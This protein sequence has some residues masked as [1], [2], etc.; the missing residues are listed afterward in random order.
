M[1]ALGI[2]PEMVKNYAFQGQYGASILFRKIFNGKF[3][4]DKKTGRWYIYK[5]GIFDDDI[6]E[7]VEDA[8]PILYDIIRYSIAVIGN[9]NQELAKSYGKDMEKAIKALTNK[10]AIEAVVNMASNGINSLG[11]DGE[12]WDSI[13]YAIPCQNGLYLIKERRLRELKYE[14]HIRIAT[15]VNYDAEAKCPNFENFINGIFEHNNE[16]IRYFKAFIGY[17]L[18]KDPKEQVIC[19]LFGGGSN[20]KSLLMKILHNTLGDLISTIENELIID[21]GRNH[22]SGSARPEILNLQGRALCYASEVKEGSSFSSGALKKYSGQDNLT[23]RALHSNKYVEFEPTHVL[24]L[25]TNHKPHF[26]ADDYAMIRRLKLIPFLAKFVDNPKNKHEYKKDTSFIEKI[27]GEEPGILNW[28]IEGAVDWI[29][30]GLD[31]LEPDIVKEALASYIKEEDNIQLFLDE[32]CELDESKKITITVL[33][34][35]YDFWCKENGYGKPMTRKKFIEKLANKGY[36]KKRIGV[37]VVFYGIDMKDNIETYKFRMEDEKYNLIG[38]AENEI[39]NEE[40][41]TSK[42]EEDKKEIS[43]IADKYNF[44][45]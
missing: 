8:F 33:Y 37:G 14:D 11:F 3:L 12:G 27:N 39:N 26:A 13:P 24:F 32:C 29:E 41:D 22:E 34:R 6:I 23:A 9:E 44:T 25:L 10:S 18:C 7:E 42:I 15:S 30:N 36:N 4:R 20:G 17:S 40:L 16:L 38:E 31:A 2:T 35:L 19:V 43:D 1:E 45:L 28:I 21:T 5:N